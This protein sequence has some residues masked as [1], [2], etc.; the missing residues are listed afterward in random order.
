ML[1]DNRRPEHQRLGRKNPLPRS[2]VSASVLDIGSLFGGQVECGGGQRDLQTNRSEVQ[3]AARVGEG[4]RALA[5]DLEGLADCVEV[6]SCV[7]YTEE[8]EEE[9]VPEHL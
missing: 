6:F 9:E 5:G 1:E 2:P 4:R 3:E 8:V 7:D